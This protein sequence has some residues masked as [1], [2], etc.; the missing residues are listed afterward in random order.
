LMP[1]ENESTTCF[2]C[3]LVLLVSPHGALDC[4]MLLWC[5]A[6]ADCRPCYCCTGCSWSELRICASQRANVCGNPCVLSLCCVQNK[7]VCVSAMGH[8][9]SDTQQGQICRN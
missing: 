9:C 5:A 3:V 7:I 6:T 2:C 4:S 1:A 8:C